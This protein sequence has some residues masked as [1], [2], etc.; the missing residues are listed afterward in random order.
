VKKIILIVSILIVSISAFSFSYKVYDFT[1]TDVYIHTGNSIRMMPVSIDEMGEAYCLV[2]MY[3]N[4]VITYI[5][6][7]KKPV[8]IPT[9][10]NPS[11]IQKFKFIILV[12]YIN[13]FNPSQEDIENFPMS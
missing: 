7:S 9:N 8:G 6:F 2:S 1:G 11:F 13:I 10:D 3:Y 12:L 4:Y 5:E